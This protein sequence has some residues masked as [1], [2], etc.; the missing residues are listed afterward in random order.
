MKVRK[1]NRK[2]K[3]SVTKGGE[4]IDAGDGMIAH[5]ASS[6]VLKMSVSVG[7][8]R[9]AEKKAEKVLENSY[10]SVRFGVK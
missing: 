1:C 2:A 4:A 6:R 3:R 9:K 5:K 8:W 10:Y 7:Q